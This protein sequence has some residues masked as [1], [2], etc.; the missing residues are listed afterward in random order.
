[1]T[2][3]KRTIIIFAGCLLPVILLVFCAG[4][5][6]AE[7]IK[8]DWSFDGAY[9]QEN[10]LRGEIVLNAKWSYRE[11]DDPAKVPSVNEKGWG[12]R[13]VPGHYS[14]REKVKRGWYAREFIVPEK[15]RNRRLELDVG[16]PQ[17]DYAMTPTFWGEA[18]VYI[19]GNH[20]GTSTKTR[21][22]FDVSDL[23]P[24]TRHQLTML[25]K[26]TR[27]D[28]WLR[29]FPKNAGI[30]ESY[31]QTSFRKKEVKVDVSGSIADPKMKQV[32]IRIE[33]AED[34]NFKKIVKALKSGP[35]KVTPEG[36]HGT[37][38]TTLKSEWQNPK[39]WSP[40][41]PNLY[42]YRTG[43]LDENNKLVDLQLPR[44]FGFREFW[45]EGRDFILNGV[46]FR[47]KGAQ[48]H[49]FQNPFAATNPDYLNFM[50]NVWKQNGL[51]SFLQHY[52]CLDMPF[53]VADEKGIVCILKVRDPAGFNPW[54]A[55][56]QNFPDWDEGMA[57][58]SESILRMREHPSIVIWEVHSPWTTA[59]QYPGL[60]GKY[61]D[62]ATYSKN[63]E[64]ARIGNQRYL[65]VVKEIKENLDDTRLVG[66][67]TGKY[68][69]FFF[70][71]EYLEI[72]L[73]LQERE[74]WFSGWAGAE[75]VKP[76]YL[77]EFSLPFVAEMFLRKDKHDMYRSLGG[78]QAKPIYLEILA[79]FEGDSAY[80]NEPEEI[81][82]AWPETWF[83]KQLYLPGAQRIRALNGYHMLRSYR[84]Y[85]ISWNLHDEFAYFFEPSG[86]DKNTKNYPPELQMAQKQKDPR[87][88]G[89][90]IIR[91]SDI[92]VNEAAVYWD[93]SE[94]GKKIIPI[95]APL[96]AY[97]GGGPGLEFSRK[98][99]LYYSGQKVRKEVI[100]IN[101]HMQPAKVSGEWKAY[102]S[103]ADPR[104]TL[105]I[106]KGQI[107]TV[108]AAGEI[109]KT[110]LP[111]EFVVP[112]VQ[113]KTDFIIELNLKSDKPGTLS[114]RF[115]I[116]VFPSSSTKIGGLKK[117]RKAKIHLLGAEESITAALR[118]MQAEYKNI[119]AELSGLTPSDIL[120]IGRHVLED[121][122]TVK[123]LEKAGFDS[124]VE[125]GLRVLIMEQAVDNLFGLTMQERRWRRAFIAAE[126]H[127]ALK[128]LSDSDFSYWS[129]DS[130]LTPPY[131][132]QPGPGWIDWPEHYWHW[133]SD[134]AVMTY[135][136]DR[137]QVGAGRALLV[138]GF[139]LKETP[140]YE[141]VRG[142]GRMIFCQLDIS[143]RY[144]KDP[145]ATKMFENLLGYLADVAGPN[146]ESNTLVDLSKDAPDG[147]EIVRERILRPVSPPEPYNWGITRGDLF[148]REVVFH[149]ERKISAVKTRNGPA[150]IVPL[151]KKVGCTLGL[152]D[153]TTGWQKMKVMWVHS[154]LKI[155]T[156]SSSADGPRADLHGDSK[157]LYPIEWKE[158]FLDP[159][160]N[161]CW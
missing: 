130:D 106:A 156:G 132:E 136:I 3:H 112:Q 125:Q 115:D 75:K 59:S 48:G 141:C 47:L 145:A 51:N 105:P 63:P 10:G 53:E 60:I 4:A 41:T 37:W 138:C 103:Y 128:G 45:V 24:G 79:M 39:L 72:G 6:A 91:P 161:G 44:R 131:A 25:T 15:W 73:D 8:P 126:G 137:P 114:D 159:Y 110:G 52:Q 18:E 20:I 33:I 127:P 123:T 135:L 155:N 86:W 80:D 84:T 83:L 78:G 38:S 74:N 64:Q 12:E 2:T 129:G 124:L 77:G 55:G 19:D 158:G 104:A 22:K 36:D 56:K 26:G 140:L 119:T 43:L 35:V 42:Y 146:P 7:P 100:I 121:A 93:K 148:M 32:S 76:V 92:W 11:A 144:K 16:I 149:P 29:S 109:R 46:I 102:L 71:T 94:S 108:L 81:I 107:E 133:G 34:K 14:Y 17:W 153:F 49:I 85:G 30:I 82:Y 97:I 147:M 139:D 1:M 50:A 40:D 120:I 70:E 89:S 118:Q 58:V 142:R 9:Q 101:D 5:N 134:N 99:H 122:A 160:I 90:S 65:R 57:K 88:R 95:L 157:A 13:L 98:D 143:N 154:A 151:D 23:V 31:I 62:P 66:G 28:L 150:V 67:A 116:T 21:S 61:Y 27:N 117:L 68:P 69:P 96:L 54:I 113:G 87:R 111:I 152:D